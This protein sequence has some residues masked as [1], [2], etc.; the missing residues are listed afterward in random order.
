VSTSRPDLPPAPGCSF[1]SDNT[2][3]AHPAVLDALARAN[4]GSALAYGADPWT[5]RAVADLRDAFDAPVEVLCCW[6][7]TGA[8]IVGLATM[9]SAW[10]SVVTVDSAHVVVDEAGGPTRFTGSTFTVVPGVDGKL[11]PDAIEPYLGWR[12]VE[13]RP[14]PRAVTISQAT[15]TGTVYSVDEL[16]AL[17]E[18]CHGHGLLVHLD[19]AR[20]AN[21][22]VATGSSLPE[23][24]R[25]TGVDVMTFGL[26]KNGAVFGDVVVHLD[27]SLA[28]HARYVRKQAGQLVSK[29][30]FVAAQVSALLAD[31]LW[32][33]NARV[34]NDAAARLAAAVGG[35]PGVRVVRPPEVNAVFA[36]VPWD[37]LEDLLAW[38]FFWPWAP[39]QHLVR[40][41]TSFQTT[42]DDVATF[43][44]GL[45]HLLAPS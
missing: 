3:G 30:R 37:R 16:G 29:S 1:A 41:M 19:G 40:W 32:L 38:S 18:W 20:I 21:A 43:A 4:E 27:T 11:V 39:E 25:D 23:M 45:R 9:V 15:E 44:A 6:G 24:V 14:Q 17:V 26:T 34:A 5:D 10:Q 28:A 13:H 7:G 35:V 33:R 22:V 2:A 8:N 36:E 12:G 31:D 42:D